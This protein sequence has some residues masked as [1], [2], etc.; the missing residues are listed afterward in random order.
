VGDEFVATMLS[1]APLYRVMVT[2]GNTGLPSMYV[3]D[4][5][6]GYNPILAHAN[7]A[8]I[9]LKKIIQ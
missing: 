6:N 1:V 3:V 8:L 9:V 5:V 2:L 7:Q 4:P